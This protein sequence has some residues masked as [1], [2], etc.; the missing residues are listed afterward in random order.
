MRIGLMVIDI[1]VRAVDIQ[2]QRHFDKYV[3]N[4]IQWMHY[5]L[6]LYSFFSIA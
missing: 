6:C 5:S 3:Y 2:K 4:K 1:L